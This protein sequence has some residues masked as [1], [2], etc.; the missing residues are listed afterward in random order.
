MDDESAKP[1][2]A[3]VSPEHVKLRVDDWSKRLNKLFKQITKWAQENDWEVQAGPVIPM[4]DEPVR[5]SKLEPFDQ[6]SL[7]LSRKDN[8]L[9]I[10]VRPKGLW[11]IGA[12]G[13]VDV[14]SSK[15]SAMLTDVAEPFQPPRWRIYLVTSRPKNEP[16]GGTLKTSGTTFKPQLLSELH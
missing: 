10:W 8:A 3:D 14:T 7:K 12:N 5:H 11:I 16:Q 13:R 1:L 6:P 2:E 15:E 4:T 9:V